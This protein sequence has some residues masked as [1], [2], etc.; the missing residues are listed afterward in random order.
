MEHYCVYGD[1][2]DM[3]PAFQDMMKNLDRYSRYIIHR[4]SDEDSVS[5]SIHST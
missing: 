3:S 2:I 5:L 1:D 4:M